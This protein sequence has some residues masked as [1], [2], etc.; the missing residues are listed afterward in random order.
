MFNTSAVKW[1]IYHHCVTTIYLKSSSI[2]AVLHGVGLY[3]AP[4]IL[5]QLIGPISKGQS[6]HEAW[7]ACPPKTALPR[8]LNMSE[9]ELPV[10]P[11]SRNSTEEPRPQLHRGRSLK[12]RMLYSAMLQTLDVPA[13]WV[14]NTASVGSSV[15]SFTINGWWREACCLHLR[16]SPREV[17]VNS[18]KLGNCS[19]VGVIEFL[20][21]DCW[22]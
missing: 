3:L 6:V 2:F 8:C 1:V 5:W 4:A 12:S 20:R 19:E 15:P 17:L 13:I 9:I 22:C 21:N 7:T 11:T 18:H 16:Y 10:L 14:Y